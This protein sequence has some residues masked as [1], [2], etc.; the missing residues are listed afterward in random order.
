MLECLRDVT[1]RLPE[2]FVAPMLVHDESRVFRHP[3]V[4]TVQLGVAEMRS[5]MLGCRLQSSVGIDEQD[6]ISVGGDGR[7]CEVLLPSPGSR[8][9]SGLN[10]SGTPF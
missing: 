10:R 5:R 6:G 9:P 8:T 7:V 3:L 1:P 2:R 4:Q